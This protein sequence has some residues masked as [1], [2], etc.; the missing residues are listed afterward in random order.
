[1]GKAAAM[2]GTVLG[3]VSIALVA[4]LVY[5][6]FAGGWSPRLPTCCKGKTGIPGTPYRIDAVI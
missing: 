5:V 2:V 6:V 3:Y 4:L 1:M